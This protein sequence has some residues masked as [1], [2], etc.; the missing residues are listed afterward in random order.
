MRFG[1]SRLSWYL[2]RKRRKKNI[3]KDG[4]SQYGQDMVVFD[5]LGRPPKG[6]FVDIGA[7]DGAT[8]SNSLLFEKKGWTGICVEPHP[9]IFE[10][11][12]QNRKCHLLNACIS[13]K[14]GKVDFL[15]VEGVAHMLSG[16][17]EFMDE[18]HL[19]RIE[20]ELAGT[21]GNKRTIE[22]QALSPQT[23]L[24]RFSFDQI[25]YLSIDTEGCE[26]AILKT[27]DFE[28]TPVLIIGVENGTRSPELFRY[29]SS[30]GYKLVKCVGCDE[31]YRRSNP[32]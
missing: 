28:K 12:K 19:E 30:I 20:R 2:K 23:L 25:D 4:H 10:T 13:D 14:D 21:D 15:V 16:I 26:L 31:I 29:M 11:L 5:L 27:F 8:F 32:A 22:I 18:R 1:S 7:N 24:K 17:L 6:V 3:R 9:V